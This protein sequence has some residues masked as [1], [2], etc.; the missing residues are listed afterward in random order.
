[1]SD[2]TKRE[3]Q[4][5]LGPELGAVFHGLWHD[6][7]S[8]LMRSNEFRELFSNAAHVELLNAIG[9]GFMWDIQQILWDDLMLRVTR[10]TDPVR[11]GGKTNLTVQALPSL[12]EDAELRSQIQS[13]VDAAV[14]AAEFARDWRNRRISHADLIRA[15]DPNAE[16]LAPASLAQVA[17][18]LNSVHTVLNAISLRLLDADIMNDVAMPPRARAFI[19]N[20]EQLVTSVKYADSLID[21]TRNQRVVDVRGARAFLQKLGCDPTMGNVMQIIALRRAARRFP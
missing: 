2:K 20:T 13:H 19:T 9:G 14:E 11:T 16:P 4:E 8:G 12:C 10:L 15:T 6:W 5:K 21:P 17:T 7:V 18:A 3:Y 1:M